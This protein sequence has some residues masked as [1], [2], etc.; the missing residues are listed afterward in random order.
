MLLYTSE[1][2]PRLEYIIGTLLP[3]I[4]I[5]NYSLID[6]KVFFTNS[7]QI[8]INYSPDRITEEEFWVKPVDLLFEKRIREQI[9]DCLNY[10]TTK[11]FFATS[12]SDFPFDIF[13]AS[14]YLVSRYE[15]YLPHKR[16]EYGRYAHQN[17]LAF[18]QG[19]LNLPLINLWLGQFSE[20]LLNKFAS[21]HLSPPAF[22]FISTYDIDIA[23]S[24]VNKGFLRNAGGLLRS[25]MDGEWSQAS[26][27]LN[28]L[29]GN[30]KDPFDSY[31]WLDELHKKNNLKPLYFFLLAKE[32][33]G[34][35]K[36]ILPSKK[37]LQKLVKHISSRYAVGIHPSWRSGDEHDLLKEEIGTLEKLSENKID[38]SRQHYIRMTLPDT[39]RRLIK[40]GI[41]E[42]YSMGYGSINGFRA[43][44]CLPYKWYDLEKEEITD[45]TI[46]PFCFMD[47]N[48]FYEQHFLPEEALAEMKHYYQ[49]TRQVNGT[50]ITIWHNHFFGT[51]KMFK[52]WQEIYTTI[53]ETI[54]GNRDQP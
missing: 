29:F 8:K 11:V 23:W 38:K 3:A 52:G 49:I 34:F 13:A 46:F 4:G 30:Q 27:R 16:D 45:L 47:A 54:T 33:K 35:D 21:L 22:K 17:S 39:Y 51:D 43:S 10:R 36:N 2:S 53:V 12:A 42:D 31:Q 24:Y 50:F 26:E 15:E 9:I 20:E 7:S 28:V 37:P 32:N 40:A 5:S 6:D 44:Y 41:K 14:F 1:I 48:S 25:T 18:R 19:V